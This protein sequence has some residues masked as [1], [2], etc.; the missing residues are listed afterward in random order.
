MKR[1][2]LSEGIFGSV[3]RG[4]GAF[5]RADRTYE[6]LSAIHDM[7]LLAFVA[8]G[9]LSCAFL[10]FVLTRWIRDGQR[11]PP[12]H[13]AAGDSTQ[14]QP[15]VV[16]SGKYAESRHKA[17]ARKRRAFQDRPSPPGGLQREFSNSE[18]A[19]YERIAKHVINR[20]RS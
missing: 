7:G 19:V 10:L 2:G 20:N 12:T 11:R 6:A 4:W 15:F 17:A 13:K 8:I 14:G 5:A 3:D 9:L 16:T 1:S 18:R